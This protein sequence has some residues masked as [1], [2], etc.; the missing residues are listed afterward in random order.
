MNTQYINYPSFQV[1][2]SGP[3]ELLFLKSV[4]EVASQVNI[5]TMLKVC[6]FTM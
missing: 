5:S 3:H 1:S 2:N 6:V 4:E